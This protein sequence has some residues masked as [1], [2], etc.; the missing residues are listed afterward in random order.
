MIFNIKTPRHSLHWYLHLVYTFEKLNILSKFIVDSKFS[1]SGGRTRNVIRGLGCL[2]APHTSLHH[3]LKYGHLDRT[4]DHPAQGVRS[5]VGH[6]SANRPSQQPI[7]PSRARVPAEIRFA[8]TNI[9]QSWIWPLKLK[10]KDQI[11][12]ACLPRTD[13][14]RTLQ[15]HFATVLTNSS[16]WGPKPS[17][18]RT[19]KYPTAR[20]SRRSFSRRP[21]RN[22]SFRG[23]V[24]FLGYFIYQFCIIRYTNYI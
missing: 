22:I 20:H 16:A 19:R 18:H 3:T 1:T 8:A 6:A 10:R 4:S 12:A 15:A 2:V 7:R 17:V 24:C 11:Q 13:T 21:A 23:E 14:S 5:R 9:V